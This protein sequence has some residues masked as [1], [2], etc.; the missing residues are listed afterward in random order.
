[1]ND[2]A[3]DSGGRFWAGSMRLDEGAG[4]ACLYRL[5]PDHR[6]H[7]VCEGVT[8]SNGLAWSLDDTL[9][10]YV[11][12]PTS[13][14]DVFDFDP[15]TGAA[16]GRRTLTK[17]DGHPDGLTADAEGFLW[18]AFWGGGQVRRY[19]PEGELAEV[20]DVPAAHTT[21]PA[22]GGA[23]LRDLYITTAAGD[24][25]HAGGLFVARP[26]VAGLPARAYAG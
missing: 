26:G 18:V 2:G 1:M 25:P 24:D 8:V 10:Y 3:C 20:V 22:F 17:V 5:D 12:T 14:I 16:T 13:A 15:A 4:G 6:V 19:S 11:D 9:L 21:K 7:T 23:D